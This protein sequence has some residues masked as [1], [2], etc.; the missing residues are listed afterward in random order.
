MMTTTAADPA[1]IE[2]LVAANR[3]LVRLDARSFSL[4]VVGVV[5]GFVRHPLGTMKREE[6]SAERIDG[7]QKGGHHAG[8]IE[9]LEQP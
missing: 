8:P 1:L 3:T 9:N 5:P 2:D 7:R 4:S 6:I